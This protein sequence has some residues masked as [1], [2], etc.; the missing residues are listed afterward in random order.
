MQVQTNIRELSLGS[1]AI[2]V[3]YAKVY[4]GYIGKLVAFG[5]TPGRKFIVL[6]TLTQEGSVVILLSDKVIRLSKPE[7]DALCVEDL[8]EEEA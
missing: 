2:I 3:G 8:E 6:D 5:L 4:G 1:V 7:V